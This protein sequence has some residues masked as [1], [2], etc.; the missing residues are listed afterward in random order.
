MVLAEITRT[1]KA[2]QS[3]ELGSN[4]NIELVG[5]GFLSFKLFIIFLCVWVF[6]LPCMYVY[7]V[8]A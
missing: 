1:R 3:L 6:Y 5:L 8:Y 7:H 2:S 4:H